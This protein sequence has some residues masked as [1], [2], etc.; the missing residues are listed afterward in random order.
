MACCGQMLTA[1]SL[2]IRF[3]HPHTPLLTSANSLCKRYRSDFFFNL[4]SVWNEYIRQ[5]RKSIQFPAIYKKSCS[6]ST[7]HVGLVALIQVLFQMVLTLFH[8]HIK[9]FTFC[10]YWN[11]HFFKFLQISNANGHKRLNRYR[12][13]I[14]EKTPQNKEII[15]FYSFLFRYT[16]RLLHAKVQ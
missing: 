11:C 1:P 8:P 15:H 4:A 13:I 10:T 6:S 9:E 14:I 7:N 12:L 16:R 3:V 2:A 5:L